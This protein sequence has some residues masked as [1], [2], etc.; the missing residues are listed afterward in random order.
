M[1]STTGGSLGM[2]SSEHT[3]AR[4]VNIGSAGGI[5]V[6]SLQSAEQLLARGAALQRSSRGSRLPKG[7]HLLAVSERMLRTCQSTVV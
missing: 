6:W 5:S 2:Q 3:L 7:M 1:D 4:D